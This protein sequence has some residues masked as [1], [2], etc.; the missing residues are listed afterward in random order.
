MSYSKE[1][2]Q[3]LVFGFSQQMAALYG[4]AITEAGL[5][6]SV[7]A[8]DEPDAEVAKIINAAYLKASQQALDLVNIFGRLPELSGNPAWVTVQNGLKSK[9]E[10]IINK[11]IEKDTP[12]L[13]KLETILGQLSLVSEIPVPGLAGAS[14][15]LGEVV[16][17]IGMVVDVVSIIGKFKSGDFS[18]GVTALIMLPVGW[19]IEKTVGV[20][21]DLLGLAA[22][23][24]ALIGSYV[25][26]VAGDSA[27]EDISEVLQ[28]LLA[29]EEAAF[30]VERYY[31]MY[32]KGFQTF[33][34]I[35]NVVA[36][37]GGSG[38]DY[39]SGIS[40]KQNVIATGA[41]DDTVYGAELTDALGG[42]SGNDLL[43]GLD[44]D[45]QLDGADGNDVLVGGAGSD[46]LTGGDGFDE[47]RFE[48]GDFSKHSG[49]VIVDADGIGKITFNGI[50]IGDLSVNNVSRDGL[51]WQ[52][53]DRAFR[54]MV[55]GSD[56]FI[57][58]RETGGWVLVENWKN[59]DLS[60]TLPGLGQPQTP[61]NPIELTD[62]D[63]TVGSEGYNGAEPSAN[64]FYSA[65][66]GNDGI[67]GGYGDDWIDGGSGNDLVLGGPG[68]NRLLGGS[69]NDVILGL[70]TVM[71]WGGMITEEEAHSFGNLIDK[72]KV[73]LTRTDGYSPIV[74][75][76]PSN[77]LK[78]TVMAKATWGAG[79]SMQAWMPASVRNGDDDIDGGDGS[80]VVYAGEGNDTVYGGTGND[81]LA[82]GT[83]HD[84]L[85]GDE[86]DDLI[87]GD[88][89]ASAGGVWA[90]SA[91]WNVDTSVVSGNDVIFGGAGN[92]R[93][94]GEG[95]NDVIDGGEGDDILQGDKVT[96]GLGYAL[97]VI[98]E[99][100]SDRIRGGDGKDHIFGDGG[101]D[102]LSGDGG[103]DI[104]YGGDG[105]DII[106]GGAGQDQ[107]IGDAGD[108]RINGGDAADLLFG[109]QGRDELSGGD[110][111]DQLSGE[112]GDDQLDGGAGDDLLIGGAGN[113]IVNGGVGADEL[114]GGSGDDQL[115]AGAGADTLFGGE[116]NDSLSGGSENDA[117]YGDE[118]NDQL[119]G[120]T[121]SDQLQ[122]GV[123]ADLLDGGVGNDILDGGE[124]DDQLRGE[125]GNDDLVGGAGNDQLDGGAQND[126]LWGGA[127]NDT[128]YGRD[129][130]DYLDGDELS[131]DPGQHGQDYL[132]GGAGSDVIHGQ[133][134]SDIVRGGDGDDVLYGDDYERLLT[135]NDKVY[136]DAGNDLV[137]GGAGNDELYGGEGNDQLVGGAGDDL[138]DGGAGEDHMGGGAGNDRYVFG[139]GSGKDV[140]DGLAAV[141]AGVDTLILGEGV[142]TSNILVSAGRDGSLVLSLTGGADTI[143]L[144]GYFSAQ[145]EALSVR[146]ASG[147]VWSRQQMLTRLT[148]SMGGAYM[149]SDFVGDTG[150]ASNDTLIGSGYADTMYG[151]AGADVLYGQGGN[152][153]LYGD[154]Q[155]SQWAQF[156]N[157]DQLYGGD[158]DD[159]LFGY[160]GADMLDGGAGAD[161][162]YGG[163]GNDIL[164][165]GAGNDNLSG[166]AGTNTYHFKA[167][168]GRDIL[169][170]DAGGGEA[171]VLMFDDALPSQVLLTR[172]SSTLTIKIGGDS[173]Q[174]NE[175]SPGQQALSLKF[176]NGAVLSWEDI[177]KITTVG[178][179][180]NDRLWGSDQDDVLEG[181]EGDDY[182]AGRAGNDHLLGGDG[183]DTLVG[184]AGDDVLDGGA[185]K[186]R[187]EGGAGR[188]I[189]V[190]ANGQGADTVTDTTST[191]RLGS[192]IGPANLV[193]KLLDYGYY[194]YL[195][196]GIAGTEDSLTF[197]IFLNG[198]SDEGVKLP[199]DRLEFAD[200]TVWGD[201]QIRALL[202]PALL[203]GTAKFDALMGDET[204]NK[205]YGF[206]GDDTIAVLGGDDTV[207]AGGGND[208]VDGGDGD[209]ELYGQTGNDVASGGAG[210]DHVYGDAGDDFVS[211]GAGRDYVF[212]D[213]PFG[214]GSSQADGDDVLR[215]D[216]GDDELDGGLGNDVFVFNLGDGDDVIVD[217]PTV[218]NPYTNHRDPGFD[219]IRFGKGISLAD[220][221]FSI[222]YREASGGT[223]G[224]LVINNRVSGDRV[225]VKYV[226]LSVGYSGGGGLIS[227]IDRIEFADGTAIDYL[228]IMSRAGYRGN[229]VV[230][231]PYNDELR[232]SSGADI[233]DGKDD[234]GQDTL[235]GGGGSDTYLFGR[236]SGRDYINDRYYSYNS[237]TG[238]WAYTPEDGVDV[239]MFD[240]DVAVADLYVDPFYRGIGI[241]GSDVF[242]AQWDGIEEFHFADGTI[243]DQAAIAWFMMAPT[244]GDNLL[245]G[246]SGDDVIEGLGG[247]DELYG[248]DGNDILHGGAGDDRLYGGGGNDLLRYQVGGGVDYIAWGE[249]FDVLEFGPGIS[250]SDVVAGRVGNTLHLAVEGTDD[251]VAIDGAFSYD[252]T[253]PALNLEVIELIRFADGA[254]MTL[255]EFVP[256]AMSGNDASQYIIGT[257]GSD[258]IDAKRGDDKVMGFGG[259]D[260]LRG[261]AGQDELNGGTGNDFLQGG[262]GNDSYI[263]SI[264][265]GHDV[266]DNRD[267]DGGY[268]NASFGYGAN[269]MVVSRTG[270]DLT[271]TFVGGSD[272]VTFLHWFDD[273]SARIDSVWANNDYLD[274]DAFEALLP[275]QAN[276]SMASVARIPV[277]L[278]DSYQRVDSMRVPAFRS[279]QAPPSNWFGDEQQVRILVEAMAGWSSRSSGSVY[280][281]VPELA[282]DPGEFWRLHAW[283]GNETVGAARR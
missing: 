278:E 116:G 1:Q 213:S 12:D 246:T 4:R 262:D 6:I 25:A 100:G 114:Q 120:G 17:G 255:E 127:G 43:K 264:G 109:G 175:L 271:V 33:E 241:A 147:A 201:S 53:A 40:G 124:D 277:A 122:G 188:D 57:S 282:Q 163:E 141:G 176:Q 26:G 199:F 258:V 10:E 72:G 107:L 148:G 71:A 112:E 207:L 280:K 16:G 2:I 244:E 238:N 212:G 177:V 37:I 243:W 108:D 232:G 223:D 77:F 129:G 130:D 233:L 11:L 59:G 96:Q 84:Y 170:F 89:I 235:S 131:L 110:G 91:T 283:H 27:E 18:G 180:G 222:T 220:L 265:D 230:G 73:W 159:K 229:M 195:S 221:D 28:N 145:D 115:S 22:W 169:T 87:F 202:A 209:D 81:V 99:D 5:E 190:L 54:M 275:S 208:V 161:Y 158:G 47:Y 162:L 167:G 214:S 125:D 106:D 102:V 19:V 164:I 248:Y 56:L 126:R 55:I 88:D 98:G 51:A 49:D 191:V 215:G 143:T 46:T 64:E 63:D 118:G 93:I 194:Q 281:A 276:E 105:D 67:D 172:D 166:G 134:N 34:G 236:N 15:M 135:G 185:G 111:N 153:S 78:F 234:N 266:V 80:D 74:G 144:N 257:T 165:G 75:D 249:G 197:D 41:G 200:G 119:R 274:A 79:G 60:I 146:F 198:Q 155:G 8:D 218:Y 216:A 7:L 85:S 48:L 268:D 204:A 31:R 30:V 250:S 82:G 66:A 193:A 95:G 113:D 231:T 263:F 152:D 267:A 242:L 260:D 252:E 224:D 210:N 44:G 182:L 90:A 259:D 239:V 62:G 65:F 58:H 20:A 217:G 149:G 160:F 270:S 69:G 251:A 39:A 103:D 240:D 179:A 178:T 97:A 137:D 38:D 68:S 3:Q 140:V 186:D 174:V 128:A 261:G 86:G 211:G 225:T 228:D 205:A 279:F 184:E 254:E 50:A 154:D 21:L 45:D 273:V 142:T 83:E 151:K 61:E 29:N 196:L 42:G 136:G 256:N 253:D 9:F 156:D 24:I 237:Q 187:L 226:L 245:K 138:L 150:L 32:G 123:G 269:D 133:G 227:M 171:A 203:L 181:K 13:E 183:N 192:G 14:K 173:V 272:S 101:N 76:A 36:M 189:Y 70:P 52:T 121:G 168:F 139:F 157:G 92:D 23:P 104:I 206:G 35:D 117:L 219:V 247:N 94:Y 132:D